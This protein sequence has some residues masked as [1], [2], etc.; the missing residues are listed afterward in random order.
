MLDRFLRWLAAKLEGYRPQEPEQ[1]VSRIFEVSVKGKIQKAVA[2]GV[3]A[4]RICCDLPE[5]NG[6]YLVGESQALDSVHF[7]KLWAQL[8]GRAEWEDGTP[9]RPP[10]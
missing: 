9:F 8:G 3:V 4:T 6:Q 2:R 10:V 7:W 5:S 1:P